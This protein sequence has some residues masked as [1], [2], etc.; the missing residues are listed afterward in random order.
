MNQNISDSDA[1][2]F[3]R[4]EVQRALESILSSQEVSEAMQLIYGEGG[5]FENVAVSQ[6]LIDA[7]SALSDSAAERVRL[8]L[9]T[10]G[11]DRRTDSSDRA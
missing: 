7:L 6:N 3:S 8:L 4:E 9:S 11:S 5:G 1:P 10:P 2:L